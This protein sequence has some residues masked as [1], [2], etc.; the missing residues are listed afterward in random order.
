MGRGAGLMHGSMPDV[1]SLLLSSALVCFFNSNSLDF[2]LGLT[3]G[4]CRLAQRLPGC[5]ERCS[6]DQD[7]ASPDGTGPTWRV[8]Y[9]T[10]SPQRG[11]EMEG[12]G[13]I[14]T[15][16]FSLRAC[17]SSHL[18]MLRAFLL[19]ASHRALSRTRRRM[20]GLATS[21]DCL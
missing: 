21:P 9:R 11:S 6:G 15:T 14:T 2:V 7:F 18:L 19:R 8:V 17:S 5:C 3:P 13:N 12:N 1:Q 4:V 20:E 16:A 10:G